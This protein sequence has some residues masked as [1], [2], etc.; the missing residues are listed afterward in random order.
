MTVRKIVHA[1]AADATK[2]IAVFEHDL[3]PDVIVQVRS[4]RGR[5]LKMRV[6]VLPDRVLV[7]FKDGTSEELKVVIIG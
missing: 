1:I 4:E 6:D 5:V 7:H 3:G 2:D